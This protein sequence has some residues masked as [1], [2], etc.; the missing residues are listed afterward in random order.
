MLCLVCPCG[1][2]TPYPEESRTYTCSRCS[3]KIE[4]K[5]FEGKRAY[6]TWHAWMIARAFLP[7]VERGSVKN[8]V[9]SQHTVAENVQQ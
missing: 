8:L 6:D 9:T 5:W 4:V 3:R 7:R 2:S 1:H